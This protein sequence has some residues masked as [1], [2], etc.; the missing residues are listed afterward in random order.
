M[1]ARLDAKTYPDLEREPVSLWLDAYRR[2]EENQFQLM[3]SGGYLMF[4]VAA[5]DQICLINCV[6]SEPA[7]RGWG[8][9][10]ATT[11]VLV[12]DALC[13]LEAHELIDATQPDFL[14]Q[15]AMRIVFAGKTLRT[16]GERKIGASGRRRF[17]YCELMR[18]GSNQSR[19]VL[20]RIREIDNRPQR[21][22]PLDGVGL[23]SFIIEAG[24]LLAPCFEY[25]S[26][27]RSKHI[28]CNIT[29]SSENRERID[30]LKRFLKR[31]EPI[32]E[33]YL[34]GGRGPDGKKAVPAI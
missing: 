32:A 16:S 2:D 13:N 28:L 17:D 8:A 6:K 24:H 30:T 18:Y 9:S 33:A 20:R 29:Y 26:Q 22:F 19:Y 1:A 31:M 34:S 25:W 5:L 3:N 21:I 10:R 15:G 12:L 7:H 4:P 23:A 14:E 11:T 27:R